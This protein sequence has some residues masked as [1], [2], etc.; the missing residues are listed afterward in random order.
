MIFFGRKKI[1]KVGVTFVAG[2]TSQVEPGNIKSG[3]SILGINGTFSS[4][5]T[6]G[7]GVNPASSAEILSTYGAFV[8]GTKVEGSLVVNNF[9]SGSSEPNASLGVNGDIYLKR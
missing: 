4:A 8:N 3:V 1:R 5:S 6:L 2:D 9:Y 7:A